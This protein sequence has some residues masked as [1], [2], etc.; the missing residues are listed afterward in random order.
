MNEHPTTGAEAH[1]GAAFDPITGVGSPAAAAEEASTGD[2]P[3]SR[4]GPLPGPRARRTP[5]DGRPHL[6][7]V[8]DD[9]LFRTYTRVLL[10]REGFRTDVAADGETALAKLEADCYHLVVCD[11]GLPDIEGSGLL[12]CEREAGR[13]TPFLFTTASR[14]PEDEATCLALG[15]IDYLRKPLVDQVFLM[16]V[17]RALERT[18]P[19]APASDDN[20]TDDEAH[21][22][23]YIVERP[24]GRG[25]MGAVYLATQRSLGRRVA[26]KVLHRKFEADGEVG[27]RFTSEAQVAASIDHP[28]IIKIH[29][30]GFD[31]DTGRPFI[32]MEYVE[33]ETL[34]QR[35]RRGLVTYREIIEVGLAVAEGLK[36]AGRRGL[37]HRDIKPGNIVLGSD[38][39][40]KILDFGVAK[41]TDPMATQLTRTGVLIGTP[42][43]MAPE[44][45]DGR[46]IDSRADLYSLG[47]VLYELLAGAR[48][49]AAEELAS[50]MYLHAWAPPRKICDVR[51]GVPARFDAIIGRLLAKRIEERYPD[52]EA[53][54]DDL[55]GVQRQL[56]K[57]GAL[58]TFPSGPRV[59]PVRPNEAPQ[60]VVPRPASVWPL[61]VLLGAGVLAAAAF[62]L[63][64]I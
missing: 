30:I 18:P 25:A 34:A 23:D 43:Y 46:S 3:T 31:G 27:L 32:A 39:V 13:S 6:L 48:P 61:W 53:L 56:A 50:M 36:A 1:P 47:V 42:E 15:A 44:Q 4:A 14:E 33:G 58:D 41:R 24:I 55:R 9:V 7:V 2:G 35:I 45:A 57:R 12:V 62:A 63:S 64:R 17:R 19:P 38:G 54:I 60:L 10:E 22:G 16:R 52:P 28:N 5:D 51:R 26:L 21:V 29:D 49:F 20:A 37:V 8:D 59:P 11:L 40:I